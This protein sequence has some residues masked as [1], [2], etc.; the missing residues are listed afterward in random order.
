MKVPFCLEIY[1]SLTIHWCTYLPIA[2]DVFCNCTE[3]NASSYWIMYKKKVHCTFVFTLALMVKTVLFTT[4]SKVKTKLF[5]NC[6]MV[7]TMLFTTCSTF[8]HTSSFSPWYPG[9]KPIFTTV[10]SGEKLRFHHQCCEKE[11]QLI[12][13]EINFPSEDGR[14]RPP[15]RWVQVDVLSGV[16]FPVQCLIA[17]KT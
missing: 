6:S 8:L 3:C 10:F 7:K 11:V 1:S 17:S 16:L 5:T 15:R 9:K 13:P 2:T 12:L 4:C 14:T